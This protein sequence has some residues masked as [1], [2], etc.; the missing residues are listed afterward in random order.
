MWTALA[1]LQN[2]AAFNSIGAM[3]TPRRVTQL[4]SRLWVTRST[5]NRCWGP[6]NGSAASSNRCRAL[7]LAVKHRYRDRSSA[8]S[9]VSHEIGFRER[10]DGAQPIWLDI[11]MGARVDSEAI[12]I[13]IGPAHLCGVVGLPP[14]EFF[15]YAAYQ[16]VL[17]RPISILI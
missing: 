12:R 2:P 15:G 6:Q 7:F 8:K 10:Y 5:A 16:G 14:R 4:F 17:R 1:A 11:R 9:L 3:P 13:D